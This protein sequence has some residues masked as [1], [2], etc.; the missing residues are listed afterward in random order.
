[1]AQWELVFA[2]PNLVLPTAGAAQAPWLGD[3]TLGSDQVAIV[4]NDDPRSADV[5]WP[6][7]TAKLLR[8]FVDPWGKKVPVAALLVRADAPTSLRHNLDALIAF[9][10]AAAITCVLRARAAA[11]AGVMPAMW[12]D[13]FDVCQTVIGQQGRLI[14]QTP[15]LT[16]LHSAHSP[17]RGMPNAIVPVA[18]GRLAADRYLSWAF[19]RIWT[20]RFVTKRTDDRYSRA[21]FRSLEVAYWALAVPTKHT[22]SVIDYGTQIALWVSAFEVLVRPRRR[23]NLAAVLD[24][25]ANYDWPDGPLKAMRYKIKINATTTLRANAAQKAYARIYR[26]RNRFLHGEPFNSRTMVPRHARGGSAP[27]DAT[28]NL[29]TIAPLLYRSALVA[30]LSERHRLPTNLT[31][32][33]WIDQAFDDHS[34]EEMMCKLLGLK[35][36]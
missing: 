26:A 19:G 8:G 35:P 2:F 1:M 21:L 32:L 25:L 20:R 30:Y 22:G 5:V 24:L 16:A 17:F 34:N 3:I 28:V 33:R 7:A 4:A 18:N 11:N 12:S 15:A 10:N 31:D 9:R 6:A 27:G 36:L 14:T 13:V 29:P 23:A